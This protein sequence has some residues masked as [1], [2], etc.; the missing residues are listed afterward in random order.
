M[1]HQTAGPPPMAAAAAA[2]EQQRPR[3]RGV[4]QR[5]WGKWAAEIR[6]PVK[7]ARVWLGTFDTAE[8]AARA[9]DDAARRFRGAKAKL[10][11]PAVA[12]RAPHHHADAALHLQQPSAAAS[13]ST[14]RRGT[15][16]AH[17]QSATPV[18]TAGTAAARGQEEEF[19]DLSR[20]A[21]I[22]QSGDLDLQAIAGGLTPAQSSTTST[23]SS[24]A[25]DKGPPGRQPWREPG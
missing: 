19:P 20:Y 5:P 7:A 18:S 22:L 10:N 14:P 11:F 17:P 8:D 23:S 4:R 13:T 12:R 9:Y 15:R 21:H 1:T 3:Y 24:M 6:D 2:A 25:R 16:P